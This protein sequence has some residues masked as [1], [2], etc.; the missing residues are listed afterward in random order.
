MK[1]FKIFQKIFQNENQIKTKKEQNNNKI[2]IEGEPEE[3]FFDLKKSLSILMGFHRQV[4]WEMTTSPSQRVA[5]PSAY[6]HW[7]PAW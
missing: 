7:T 2:K 1:Y 6:F 4:N 3:N 5:M